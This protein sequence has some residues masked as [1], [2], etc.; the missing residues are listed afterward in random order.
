M[1]QIISGVLLIQDGQYVVQKRDNIPNIAEPGMLALWGGAAKNN[2]TPTSA[3]VRELLEET[4]LIVNENDLALLTHYETHGRSPEFIGKT[5][6]VYLFS[7]QLDADVVVNC[8]EGEKVV[9]FAALN[10]VIKS[11]EAPT[12]FLTKAVEHYETKTR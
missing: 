4:G 10:E 1:T 5:I 2:E 9:R 6:D 3:C 7:M 11:G 12:E 8:F